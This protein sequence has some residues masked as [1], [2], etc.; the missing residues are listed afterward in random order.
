LP[1]PPLGMPP[2]PPGL[3]PGQPAPPSLP[4]ADLIPQA[5]VVSNVAPTATSLSGSSSAANTTSAT[6]AFSDQ[7]PA[8][9][10]SLLL[11][12]ATDANGTVKPKK[13]L[14]GGLTLVF[15]AESESAGEL[16]MEEVRASLPRYQKILRLALER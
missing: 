10:V 13:T 6:A 7:A 16:C 15:D 12:Q 9:S 2:L 8:T 11:T 4:S 5:R 14:K 1:P 3:P